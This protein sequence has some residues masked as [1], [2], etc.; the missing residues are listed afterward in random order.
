MK[1]TLKILIILILIVSGLAFTIQ[2]LGTHNGVT[3]EQINETLPG[4]EIIP[5]PWISIDRAATL[6]VPAS[7]AW[8]WVQQLG[9]DRG[10][11]YA[12]LWLENALHEHAASSTLPQFQDLKVGDVVPDW[13][14]GSLKVL[15]LQQ[16]QYVVYGSF[17]AGEATTTAQP[18]AF[19]WALVLE[20]DT[21][22][23]TSFHLRLRLARPSGGNAHLIPP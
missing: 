11:W 12:P 13:G 7:A 10:G 18:Y 23:S 3:K 2:Y 5:D 14:G 6:P 19:I 9:K 1:R 16:D 20:N 22:T 8:P 15:A 17:H 21:P 4:D